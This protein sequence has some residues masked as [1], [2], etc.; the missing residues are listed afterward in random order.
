MTFGKHANLL[1]AALPAA[2]L[3]RINANGMP[4]SRPLQNNGL[5]KYE[6]I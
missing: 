1:V 4:A 5:Q 2:R 6:S 3:E